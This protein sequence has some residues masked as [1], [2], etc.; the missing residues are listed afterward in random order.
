[1]SLISELNLKIDDFVDHGR[2]KHIETKFHFLRDQVS[3]GTIRLK[4]YRTDLQLADIMTKALK[5][6]RFKLLRNMLGGA[7]LI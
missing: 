5:A 3:K 1:M 2:S 7:Y 6:N 4:H